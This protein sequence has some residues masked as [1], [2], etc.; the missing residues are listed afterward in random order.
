MI[1]QDRGQVIFPDAEAAE[2]LS[3]ESWVESPAL[4][5]LR[6]TGDGW[7]FADDVAVTASSA[8]AAEAMVAAGQGITFTIA[9]RTVDER[10]LHKIR[11][12]PSPTEQVMAALRTDFGPLER[13]LVNT[14]AGFRVARDCG[15]FSGPEGVRWNL[16]GSGAM[17]WPF[18]R[19]IG[20]YSFVLAQG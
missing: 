9:D 5:R 12:N 1:G 18:T 10:S 4:L 17:R 16:G 3:N 14:V 7:S 11:L 20:D 6:A 2:D 8:Q 13:A 19:Q 15:D